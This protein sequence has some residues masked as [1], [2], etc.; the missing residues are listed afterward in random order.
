MEAFSFVPHPL[1]SKTEEFF[2][3]SSSLSGLHFISLL[4]SFSLYRSGLGMSHHLDFTEMRSWVDRGSPGATGQGLSPP[5]TPCCPICL[6][7]SLLL[8]FQVTAH[9]LSSGSLCPNSLWLFSP[10]K[11]Y[12]LIKTLVFSSSSAQLY[13]CLTSHPSNFYTIQFPLHFPTFY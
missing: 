4:G 12:F 10:K 6:T 13:P 11:T 7:L 5:T 2:I 8:V 1:C 9:N 3:F